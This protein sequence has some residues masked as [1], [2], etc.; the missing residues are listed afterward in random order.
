M[1]RIV[2]MINV[3]G[4]DTLKVVTTPAGNQGAFCIG[5]VGVGNPFWYW[6]SIPA[7]DVIACDF[8]DA[9]ICSASFVE[10]NTAIAA[11]TAEPADVLTYAP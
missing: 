10:N 9:P 7:G 5:I 4:V 2:C 6:D 11:I 8:T 3:D 1:G